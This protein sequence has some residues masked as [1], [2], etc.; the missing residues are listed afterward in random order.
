[1]FKI[2]DVVVYSATGVCEIEDICVKSFGGTKCNYYIL[3]PLMQKASTLFIPIENQKLTCKMHPILSQQEFKQVFLSAKSRDP[4][5]PEG[6]NERREKFTEILESGNRVSLILMV[7]DLNNFK[8]TQQESGRRLHLADER[9]LNSAENLLYEELAYVFNID[10][11]NVSEF[12][13][14]QFK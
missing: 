11:S 12:L 9:L 10:P 13:D 2:G 5:R 14:S 8:K 7:Y 6:E 4:I 3:R 1:M